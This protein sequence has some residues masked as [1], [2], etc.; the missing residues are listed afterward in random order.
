M[1]RAPL[2]PYFKDEETDFVPG[3]KPI[4]SRAGIWPHNHS[5]P[6]LRTAVLIFTRWP[7]LPNTPP[8]PP[9]ITGP[10]LLYRKQRPQADSSAQTPATACGTAFPTIPTDRPLSPPTYSWSHM[11]TPQPTCSCLLRTVTNPKFS[12]SIYNRPLFSSRS[13]CSAY[14]YVQIYA[15]MCM[16]VSFPLKFSY[17]QTYLP[18]LLS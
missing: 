18:S 14:K 1:R 16:C 3:H 15:V 12:Q 13:F 9:L 8:S 17:T 4:S 6:Y 11:E 10:H 5:F 7:A 2:Y